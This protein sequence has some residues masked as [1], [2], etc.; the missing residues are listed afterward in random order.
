MWGRLGWRT[1]HRYIYK[2]KVP[3]AFGAPVR[4]WIVNIYLSSWWPPGP[5]RERASGPTKA[6]TRFRG[7]TLV[8]RRPRLQAG[9]ATKTPL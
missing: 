9:T 3:L 6:A 8:F 1:E 2:G 4:S 5:R 7:L